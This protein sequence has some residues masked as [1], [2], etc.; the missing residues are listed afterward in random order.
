[1]RRLKGKGVSST[2]RSQR[3][4]RIWIAILAFLVAAGIVAGL[5]VRQ[6]LTAIE[7]PLVLAHVAYETKDWSKAADYARV[8]LKVDGG[9]PEALRLLARSSIRMGRDAAGAAIY[10]DRLGAQGMQAED[11][12]L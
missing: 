3:Q 7:D 11:R 4:N 12:Y 8:R 6:R 10:N 5:M 1:M 2:M 9:D